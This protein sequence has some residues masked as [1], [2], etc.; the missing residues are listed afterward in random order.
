[1]KKAALFF[2]LIASLHSLAGVHVVVRRPAIR[3]VLARPVITVQPA[4][5]WVDINCNRD[6]ARVFVNGSLAGKTDDF[7]GFPGKLKLKPGTHRIRVTWMGHSVYRKVH[8]TVG[9]ETNL[10]IS[11]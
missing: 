5:G 4:V 11:F 6:D 10:N 2:L 8:V 3:P 1:M 9:H 7:D